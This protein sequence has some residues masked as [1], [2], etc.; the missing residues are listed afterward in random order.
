[1]NNE[2]NTQLLNL[3]TIIDGWKLNK[4]LLASK[5]NMKHSTF[6]NKINAKYPQYKLTESEQEKLI[7]VLKEMA[8]DIENNF[9][10]SF[11]KALAK[12]SRKKVQ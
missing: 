7:E 1:M 11:N 8:T 12:I 2:N 6:K 9:G 10:I 3:L 4:V 5:I